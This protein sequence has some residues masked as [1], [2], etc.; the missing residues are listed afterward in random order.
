MVVSIQQRLKHH[1]VTTGRPTVE[2]RSCRSAITQI[3]AESGGSSL[4]FAYSATA[5][6]LNASGINSDKSML[7]VMTA[8]MV[9]PSVTRYSPVT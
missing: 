9:P 6:S 2:R 7:P 3:R 5:C 1:A 8:P 4:A